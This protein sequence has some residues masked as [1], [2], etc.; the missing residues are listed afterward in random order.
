ML[1]YIDMNW[2]SL[3]RYFRALISGDFGLAVT[4]WK[5]GVLIP[6]LFAIPASIF[7]DDDT[8]GFFLIAMYLYNI[9]VLIGAWNA[10]NKYQGDKIWTYLSQI[11]V[12]I[13][14]IKIGFPILVI[15]FGIIAGFFSLLF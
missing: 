12:I 5:F 6:I 9:P 1:R 13:S 15:F 7:L 14:A 11:L 8:F 10:S 3:K 2:D 4:V